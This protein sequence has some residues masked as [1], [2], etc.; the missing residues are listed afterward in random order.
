MYKKK[1]IQTKHAVYNDTCWP[2]GTVGILKRHTCLKGFR[3][4]HYKHTIQKSRIQ[5]KTKT[6]V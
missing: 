3:N 2:Q 1:A 5:M 6:L 4:S